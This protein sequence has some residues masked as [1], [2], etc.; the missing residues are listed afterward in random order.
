[1]M[2]W[3]DAVPERFAVAVRPIVGLMTV[4]MT[5]MSTPVGAQSTD[6]LPFRAGQWAAEF[7]AADFSGVGAL[8]FTNPRRA[9]LVDV[10]GRF[11]RQS[12]NNDQPNDFVLVSDTDAFQLRMGRRSY[13]MLAPRVVRQ[14]TL[15]LIGSYGTSDVRPAALSVNAPISFETARTDYA[16]G[17][18]AELGA[19]WMITPNLGF[20]AAWTA[21]VQAGRSQVERL[22]AQ[23]PGGVL[24]TTTGVNTISGT[25]GALSVRGTL[26]F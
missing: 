22:S 6:S 23:L 7:S 25:L 2:L 19:Q 16:A 17:V 13:G 4:L 10:Q 21:T 5:V 20:G 11:Y 1:M 3:M 12:G 24:R 9:W 26:Y 15:G 8:R 14:V 18:F